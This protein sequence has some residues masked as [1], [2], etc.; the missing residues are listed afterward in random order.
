MIAAASPSVP[1]TNLS[2]WKAKI[3]AEGA[4][5]LLA[6]NLVLPSFP[7][8]PMVGDR[9]AAYRS[10]SLSPSLGPE[11][12]AA[13]RA[14][15]GN[16]NDGTRS[17]AVYPANVSAPASASGLQPAQPAFVGQQQLPQPRGAPNA[18]AASSFS[19]IVA[20]HQQVTGAMLAAS[21]SLSSSSMSSAREHTTPFVNAD[22]TLWTGGSADAA[23]APFR[24]NGTSS[25]VG[26]VTC[27]ASALEHR[28]ADS[29]GPAV[30]QTALKNCL[31]EMTR[32]I[33]QLRQSR[34]D[35]ILD[36]D[37]ADP[38]AIAEADRKITML[39]I[40]H[41]EI[42]QQLKAT[43]TGMLAMQ[44]SSG[45]VGAA[46]SLAGAQSMSGIGGGGGMSSAFSYAGGAPPSMMMM[47]NG[48]PSFGS[49]NR[50]LHGSI[51]PTFANTARHMA[52]ASAGGGLQWD[53]VVGAPID[54][55]AGAAAMSGFE[56]NCSTYNSERFPWSHELRRIMGETFGLHYFRDKQLDVL[57]AVMDS[58]D[59]FVLLPTG[60][61]KSLCYQL[62]VLMVPTQ[63]TFVFSPLVSLIQDQVSALR[64]LDIPSVALTA[65]TSDH[66][67]RQLL[68]EWSSDR[69]SVV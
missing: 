16:S 56:V 35:L 68:Q 37:V 67:R 58:K 43:A 31:R 1:R 60:G 59:V 64:V 61:G 11:K 29:A 15:N 2:E 48:D 69:K 57:N 24:S 42:M 10:V 44:H 28:P 8:P 52:S 6:N 21:S 22:R 51:Q 54:R 55:R 33:S 41:R 62:P 34:D 18:P 66:D 4:A 3:A 13:V 39:E 49:V 17:V 45:G 5:L 9:A 26:S 46:V 23:A 63:V 14:G 25:F 53:Q 50:P 65:G 40:R 32:E 27:G 19:Q 20:G 38:M 7:L 36:S 30:D 12:P 47:M